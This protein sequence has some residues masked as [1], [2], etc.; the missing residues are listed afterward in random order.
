ML[1]Y[2]S[3]TVWNNLCFQNT[4]KDI[5]YNGKAFSA[6]S[7]IFISISCNP[8]EPTKMEINIFAIIIGIIWGW[9]PH[10]AGLNGSLKWW[11]NVDFSN[12]ILFTLCTSYYYTENGLNTSDTTR[13]WSIPCFCLSA[14]WYFFTNFLWPIVGLLLPQFPNKIKTD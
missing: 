2:Y 4:K 1:R 13:D 7:C 12:F 14:V 10:Y 9:F 5:F 11:V 8:Q 6:Y 3:C